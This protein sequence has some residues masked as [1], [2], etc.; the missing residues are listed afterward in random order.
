VNFEHLHSEDLPQFPGIHD[1]LSIY[2]KKKNL[3]IDP[4]YRGENWV[5]EDD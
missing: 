5:D 4:K 3:P 1:Y 2:E